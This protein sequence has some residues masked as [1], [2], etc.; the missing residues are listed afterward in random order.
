MHTQALMRQLVAQRKSNFSLPQP[1]YTDEALFK[2]D[3]ENLFHKQWLFAG[4]DCEVANE[5]DYIT[6]E[7]GAQPVI[8]VR[9]KDGV[10]NAFHNSC[11]HR[12]SRICSEKSGSGPKLVCPYHQ[13]TYDLDGQ[14]QFAKDMG[15]NF[16]PADYKLERTHCQSVG[17]SI[18]ICLAQQAPDFSEFTQRIEPYLLPHNLRDAKVAHQSTIV[19][20]GNW[21]LVVE[22]NRECY[23][24]QGS[25]PELCRTYSD[26]PALTGVALEGGSPEIEAHWQKCEDKGIPSRFHMH[27]G[28]QYRVSRIPL[29][30]DTE[31]FTM[32]GAVASGKPMVNGDDKALGSLLLFHY[33]NTWNH[34]LSDHA[35]TFQ[36]IPVSATR[37]IVTTKWLVHKDA[38]EGV[39]YDLDTLTAVWQATNEQDRRLVEENQLGINSPGYTPGPYSPL[40]ED[41][42]AQFVD[43][44][45]QATAQALGDAEPQPIIMPIAAS[46]TQPTAPSVIAPIAPVTL[47][48]QTPP[49]MAPE[50]TA[51]SKYFEYLNQ[52]IPWR[53]QSQ[54][55]EVVSIVPEVADVMTITF[56][57]EN[58]AYFNFAP[59]QFITLELSV[60]GENL[61][62]TYTI[63]SS[64]SRPYSLSI[65]VKA[66]PNSIGTRWMLD[67]LNPGMKVRAF[68]PSGQFHLY[69]HPAEKY[70]FISAGSGITPMAS[71]TNFLYDRGGDM[72]VSFIHC[73]RRPSE[74]I[75]KRSLEQMAARV[76]GIHL[77]W[78]VQDKD[79]FS[80]WTGYVGR[81]N[82]LILELTTPDF[83]D[84]EVFCCG[85]EPFMQAVRDVLIAADFNMAQYHEESFAAPNFEDDDIEHDD[86]QLDDAVA[87]KV[88]FL[89]SGHQ[90]DSNQNIT[91]LESANQAGLNIPSACNF[92]VCGTCK[93]KKV[94][95]ETH[96]VHNGGISDADIE[97]GYILACC[98]KPITDVAISY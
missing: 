76:P 1:F 31:S 79:P 26:D 3:M 66:Q 80:A 8:I 71:M 64:P 44:Y 56:R 32:S 36:V 49:L 68:G 41:G 20:E 39:D 63:S 69:H 18:F 6:L 12:G 50:Q 87:T 14:L 28:G 65:T 83:F 21:K 53:D 54:L 74:I 84:R 37:T 46:P 48:P 45:C 61:Y 67:H 60:N 23:H 72:D 42:V 92:G 75:F 52:S 35:I 5:G 40:H 38:I 29:L 90:L 89:V 97:A 57:T 91:V 10:I 70:C 34:F 4:H 17:G 51:D 9:G 78:I 81:F 2:L 98:S 22:N 94:S 86:V 62:R 27:E 30:R 96:M 25:H 93:V 88:H 73:A 95:G 24:C 11:K 33:P 82:Q 43:W 47:A 19:E 58:N 7:I 77:A 59:G 13:W 85:P 16:N 55:L 15:P